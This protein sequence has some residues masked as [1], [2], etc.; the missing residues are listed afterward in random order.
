MDAGL[1]DAMHQLVAIYLK[2]SGVESRS[3]ALHWSE[4]AAQLGGP[5][6]QNDYAWLLATS[7]FD[8]L[9]NGTRALSAAREAVAQSPTAAYL[10]TLAAVYAELG[11]F[12][13]AIATQKEA[14]AA[15]N[16]EQEGLRDEL[17]KRLELYKR[18]QPWRE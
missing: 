6:A 17:K 5:Q 1:V 15:I 7:K 14:L 3:Q 10:D 9:R 2:Q 8:E 13:Q 12:S 18:S 11:D 4:R 16:T